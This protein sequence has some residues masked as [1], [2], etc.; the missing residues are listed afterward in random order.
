MMTPRIVSWSDNEICMSPVL[1]SAASI[2][3]FD[4]TFSDAHMPPTPE[5]Y[6]TDLGARNTFP[7]FS[8]GEITAGVRHTTPDESFIR[9]DSYFF[10]DGNVIFLVR[11]FLW[12]ELPAY[13]PPCRWT[14]RCTASIV[15]SFLVIQPTSPR[16]LPGLAYVTTKLCRLSYQ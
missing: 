2:V 7:G 12:P 9:H 4:S 13:Q 8:D 15:T 5:L 3:S 14:A 6:G 11:N 1:S 10:K 16:D